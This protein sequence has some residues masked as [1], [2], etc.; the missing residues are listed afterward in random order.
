VSCDPT[1]ETAQSPDCSDFG[2]QSG[3]AGSVELDRYRH[4]GEFSGTKKTEP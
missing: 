1:I 3:V 2:L 4:M